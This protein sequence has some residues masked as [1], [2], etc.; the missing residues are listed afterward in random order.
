[1]KPQGLII[2]NFAGGGGASLGLEMAYGRSPDIAINHD[3]EALAMH[4]ANHPGTRHYPNDVWGI[5][6]AQVTGGQPVAVAW[7]SPDCK[8]F[9]KAKGGKPVKRHIRDLAWI[10]QRWARIAR[11][12]V[13]L[14]ENVEE[15]RDWGPLTREGVPC[16]KRKGQTFRHWVTALERM[17]YA[18]DWRELRACDFGAPTIR[19]RLIV[20]ARCDGAPI[21]WPEP[22]HAPANDPRVLSGELEPYRT[23][24]DIIDWSIPCPSIFMT[25]EEARELRRTTGI[26]CNRPLADNTMKRIAKGVVRYV[27]ENPE[28]FIVSVAHGYSGGRR[29]YGLDEPLGTATHAPQ[30]A[31]VSP[32]FTY[33]QQGGGNRDASEPLHT[34]CAS[35]KDQNALAVP[36]FVPRYGERPG[37]EPRTRPVTQPA[38]VI[39]PTG[40]GAS[41]IAP[42]LAQHNTGVVGHDA[43]KPVS[44]II[45]RATTQAVVAPYLLN[46]KGSERR[47]S[48]ASEPHPTICAGGGHAAQVSAFLVKYYGTDQDPKL[49]EPLHTVTTKDRFGLVTVSIEGEP[50]VLVDIGMRMLTP[51]ELFRAQGFPDDYDITS[52]PDGKPLTLTAQRRMCGNSVSPN[53]AQAVASANMPK[54]RGR[55][56][57]ATPQMELAVA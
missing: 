30:H 8:H 44:T 19:K 16:S 17:G 12:Q 14:L 6:P 55:I 51:R 5:D 33:A 45:Q 57:K 34:I 47:A 29:E 18:V 9:S 3:P 4:E 35:P 32:V 23:A 39:V 27:L 24:A 22:T 20:V 36:F 54:R 49:S 53:I 41:L 56:I 1:M 26:L 43:R 13:I 7:F 52:G 50:Y 37:Q 28:P 21:V 2:D 46:L 31:V 42:F 10:V 48:S 11:P 25:R 40:N 38:P 15:F